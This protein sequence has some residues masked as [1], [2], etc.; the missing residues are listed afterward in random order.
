MQ[1]DR[2]ADAELRELSIPE[3]CLVALVGVSGSGKSEFARRHFPATSVLSSDFFRGLVSDDENDQSASPA[4]FEAL[5][6]VASKR[7]AAG[8]LT[9]V[10]ATNVQAEARRA[11]VKLARDHDVL[12]V[13]IVLDLPLSV[14]VERN[15]SRADRDFPAQVLHR[16]ADQLRRSLR[17]LEREGFRRVHRLRSQAEAESAM[18]RY[19]P[20]LNDLRSEHGPFDVVGDVHGCADELVALLVSL[21]YEIN[22]DEEGRAVR[23]HHPAGRRVVFL[24]DLVDRGPNT[25]GVLRLAMGMVAEGTALAVAGNHEVRLARALRGRKVAVSHGLAESLEQLEREGPAFSA[26]VAEFCHDLLAHYVLDDGRL[27]VAHAGLKES[28][29][30]RASA[31]VRDFCLYGDTTGETD[32][33]GLPVRYPWAT[34]YRGAATVLYGHVPVA[35]PEWLNNTLCLDTGCV[36]GGSLTALRY[37]ERELVSVPAGSIWYQPAR[38]VASQVAE[39]SDRPP[40]EVLDI[41]DVLGH[42]VIDTKWLRG[43]SLRAENAAAALEVMSRYAIAPDWLT[44]LP[45]TMAPAPSASGRQQLEHPTA[46]FA[47]YRREGV[48]DL[49]CEE[50]HMGSRAVALVCRDPA[51]AQRRFGGD[52]SATGAL[53]TRTGRPFFDAGLSQ[54]VLER[55]GEYIGRAG[56]WQELNTDWLLL[57]CELMPWNAKAEGLLKETY[58]PVAAAGMAALSASVLELQ[59]ASALGA[60]VEDLISRTTTRRRNVLA[61]REVYR[62]YRWDTAG[63]DGLRLAPF[64]LLASQGQTYEGLP[65]LWHLGVADRL[66]ACDPQFISS[67]KRLVVDATQDKSVEEGVAW[68]E[69]LT[70]SGGEGMVVKPSRNLTVGRR[71]LV[72]P[73]LKVR[74][75]EYLRLVYGPDYLDPKNLD[76]LQTRTVGRKR[77]LALR[78]YAL[79]MQAIRLLV[80]DAPLWKRHQ[81]VF[82]VL[83]LES[84]AVDPRL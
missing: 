58:A 49:L 82:A 30:G 75:V 84:E 20:L 17:Q 65:H 15:R 73:G 33:L 70:E 63:I 69:G 40:T 53:H 18:I 28:F 37:P 38:P 41:T 44:Y 36:F 66:A 64:Q 72:Q 68:W 4:A 6:F 34:E 13:A 24:G 2:G 67:T 56:L 48:T 59:G 14:C 19:R 1:L 25:P 21:G 78:E 23:G 27:V 32:E 57:D 55:L 9:V 76:R 62:R 26:E 45:P 12:P 80:E 79:G 50:K 22:W 51:V 77:S 10:D 11:L 46:A 35:T 83:A 5:Y 16:Q 52:G 60:D 47:A 39:P 8:R 74:G 71:G 54:L 3:T 7:L 31:R 61:Y 43:I 81:L 42:R 29:Q